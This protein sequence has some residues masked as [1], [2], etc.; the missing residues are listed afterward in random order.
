MK[1]FV[2]LPPVKAVAAWIKFEG[3][4]D[5]KHDLPLSAPDL[6]LVPIGDNQRAIVVCVGGFKVA[7]IY[8][9]LA[10][11]AT[12]RSPPGARW[13]ARYLFPE[14]DPAFRQI[15]RR[16]FHMDTVT[17]DR[18]DAVAPH[19][20]GRVGDDPGVILQRHPKSAIGQYL[21]DDA[22]DGPQLFFRQFLDSDRSESRPMA[23]GLSSAAIK[24]GR[25][26]NIVDHKP[27]SRAKAVNVA[28]SGSHGNPFEHDGREFG[29]LGPAVTDRAA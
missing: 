11:S 3:G 21:V 4:F 18:S 2:D 7:L 8:L 27:Q 6:P 25:P 19:L 24:R 14:D 12:K 23:V 15:V 13:L 5:A 10:E 22:F 1:Q 28:V 9:H 26:I 16:H 29:A 17:H 20:A